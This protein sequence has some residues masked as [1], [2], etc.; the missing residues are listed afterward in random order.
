VR[1]GRLGRFAAR[2]F[3]WWPLIAALGIAGAVSFVASRQPESAGQGPTE[4]LAGD[5]RLSADCSGT[6]TRWLFVL[7]RHHQAFFLPTLAELV[8]KA[9]PAIQFRLVYSDENARSH[10]RR[11]LAARGTDVLRRVQWHHSQQ[12]LCPWPRDFLLTGSDEEG[13]NVALLHHPEH[14][15][16]ARGIWE[17]NDP[18]VLVR[19]LGPIRHVSTRLRVEGGEVVADEERAFVSTSALNSTVRHWE[20][21]SEPAAR[22]LFQSTWGLPVSWI[23]HEDLDSSD[24]CD[25][26]LMPVGR[27]RIVVGSPRLAARLLATAPVED[28]ERFVQGLR[29][30]ARRHA[31]LFPR[32]LDPGQ[33]LLGEMVRQSTAPQRLRAFRRMRRELEA[34]RYT[35][36][37][38]PFLALD[39][40]F[41]D[42]RLVLT[43]TNVIQD[44][45]AGA[46]TV[47]LP[48]YRLAALDQWATSA[49]KGLGYRVVPIHAVGPAMHGGSLRCAS[50]VVKRP[51]KA[52]S[53]AAGPIT[54]PK[55]VRQTRPAGKTLPR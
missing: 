51:S 55:T 16:V 37:E 5:Y 33:D 12:T 29:T 2:A 6:I 1:A 11:L 46:R 27:R 20:A 25:L 48:R 38:V 24:H 45:R 28:R 3:T 50:V 23:A 15:Q 42:L 32:I 49:W 39:P 53:A 35:C 36:V 40:R 19:G 54:P 47:Y 17:S 18:M 43:Y 52:P 41:G 4:A 13:E 44:E 26:Y 7:P 9:D 14:Y 31:T 10:M 8:A 21:P 30:L 22:E 34:G